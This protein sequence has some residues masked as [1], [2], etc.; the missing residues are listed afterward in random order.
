MGHRLIYERA[1]H[2]DP[3]TGNLTSYWEDRWP[4]KILVEELVGVGSP[5]FQAAYMNDPSALEGNTLKVEWLHTYLPAELEAARAEAG[6]ERGTVYGGVDPTQGGQGASADYFAITVSERIHNRL[7]LLGYHMDRKPLDSQPQLIED[8][9]DQY[10]PH[11]T[12]FE[13]LSTKGYVYNALTTQINGGRGTKHNFKIETPQNPKAAI[14]GK[15]VRF[16]F[17]AARFQNGQIRLPG[18]INPV[19]GEIEIDSRWS[20]FRDQ[21]AAHP[22]GH[23]DLLDSTYWSQFGAFGVSVAASVSKGAG[24]TITSATSTAGEPS[25]IPMSPSEPPEP[26]EVDAHGHAIRS[27]GAERTHRRMKMLR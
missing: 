8:Y 21:W 24:G 25:T 4:I 3:V 9:L 13:D 17:M 11:F 2:L 10:M 7:Y 5:I 26:L 22:T 1:I 27:I 23:D 20:V 16:L 14:G 18:I 19:S 12:T 6:V 15:T